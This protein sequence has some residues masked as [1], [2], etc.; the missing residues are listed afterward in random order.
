[1]ATQIP[2]RLLESN[3][4]TDVL[5]RQVLEL[6]CELPTANY[7]VYSKDHSQCVNQ[8]RQRILELF[9]L[10]LKYILLFFLH[11]STEHSY[12]VTQ[13]SK[14][15]RYYQTY[16][17]VIVIKAIFLMKNLGN[18]HRRGWWIF[19]HRGYQW[20]AECF[21]FPGPSREISAPTPIG[22]G[23]TRDWIAVMS[24]WSGS[25][26]MGVLFSN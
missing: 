21:A 2:M 20:R 3:R 11:N 6:N 15:D 25:V 7:A 24:H 16:Y 23:G 13:I 8:P 5:H 17:V 19:E 26:R 12:S 4:G 9:G 22:D 10:T 1:M 14:D 18:I